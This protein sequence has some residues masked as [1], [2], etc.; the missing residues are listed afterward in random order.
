MYADP[1]ANHLVISDISNKAYTGSEIKPKVTVTYNGETLKKSTDYTVTYTNNTDIGT[2]KV[3]VKGINDYEGLSTTKSFK[4]VPAKVTELN[5][6][7]RATN[8]ISFDWQKVA[9]A[10]GYEIQVYQNY[11]WKT[12]GTSTYAKYTVKSLNSATDYKFRVRAYKTVD[13]KKYYG[14]YSDV[15]IYTTTP[16][17][18]TGI[19]VATR[20][21]NYLKLT[22]KNQSGA[23][24]NV[25]K[26]NYSTEKYELYKQTTTNT[27]KISNL[28]PAT[29]YKFRVMAVKEDT[30]GKLIKGEKSDAFVTVTKPSAPTI[31]SAKSSATKKIKVS[32][33]K[34]TASGYQVKWSTTKDFSSN[35]K[36]T[37]VKSSLASTTVKT[38]QSGK[39]YYVKV[40]AY[41]TVDGKKIYS[42]WSK[43]L[44]V[45]TK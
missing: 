37:N 7:A 15:S 27:V 2:A 23:S 21:T 14:S 41:K 25:Y 38:A 12:A 32:W 1:N 43:P 3:T 6:T 34:T 8:L 16:D 11:Q 10:D 24:Y 40:R 45:K 35:Y 5:M 28:K 30:N 39:T 26:Y 19:S 13:S 22:W 17:K 18:V 44:S 20:S 33:A 36:S 4:I 42:S 9:N 29:K 31:K